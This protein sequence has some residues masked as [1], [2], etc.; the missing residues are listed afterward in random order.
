MGKTTNSLVQP[1]PTRRILFSWIGHADLR[2]MAASLPPGQQEEVLKGLNPPKPMP[3]QPGPLKC[4]LDQ[5]KFDEVHLLSDHSA[6][7][8][9]HYLKWLGVDPVLH[10]VKLTNP[11]DY[12]EVFK[13]VDAELASVVSVPRPHAI[14]LCVHLSP[15]TPTMTAICLLLG[16]SKYHPTTFYQAHECKAWVTDIPFDLVVE[17]V[18]QVMRD[19]DARLQRLASQSPQ[20]VAGFE[21]IVGESR[22]LRVAVGSAR[23]AAQRD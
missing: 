12:P 19:A 14:D 21:G 7:K 10:S 4:L 23:R 13:V 16:K 20:D 18:P 17:F 15:G 11:T 1:M 22:S 2:A 5:E 6:V 3:G 9:R 8:N